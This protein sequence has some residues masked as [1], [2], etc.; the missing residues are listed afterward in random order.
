MP[1]EKEEQRRL[2]EQKEAE[3]AHYSFDSSI[4]DTI[5]DHAIVRQETR[6]GLALTGM[7]SYS[8]GYFRRTIHYV[9]DEHGYRVVKYVQSVLLFLFILK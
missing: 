1:T 5:N 3:S 4:Q 9:A 8:D 7:Y 2:R 6:D